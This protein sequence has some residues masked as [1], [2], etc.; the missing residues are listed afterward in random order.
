MV[1]LVVG[2]IQ[3]MMRAAV[4][5][6]NGVVVSAVH[7]Q[8]V[9]ALNYVYEAAERSKLA[10]PKVNFHHQLTMLAPDS[11][12]VL[13]VFE[14]L[15]VR[16]DSTTKIFERIKVHLPHPFHRQIFVWHS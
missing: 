13:G 10:Q 9:A 11:R 16:D 6:R 4:V 7:E 15:Q 2:N 1:P 8:A 3:T 14:R 12:A 5:S